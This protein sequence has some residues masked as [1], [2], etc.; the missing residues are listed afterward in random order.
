M[1][2]I[3]FFSLLWLSMLVF[4][5]SSAKKVDV[6]IDES[7]YPGFTKTSSGLY[8]KD[9]KEGTG[10]YLIRGKKVKLH[11][12]GKLEN[13]KIFDSSVDRN[14]PL[15]FV[16]GDLNFIKGFNE[17]LTT[18]RVGGKKILVIHPDIGYGAKDKEKIPPYSILI[19]EIE[20][21]SQE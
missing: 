16:Y 9:I 10:D 8:F 7:K 12:H 11:Y 21:L 13:G 19:F 4:G 18:I 15:E 20:V 5:C 3:C 14:Q 2:Y 1:K 6:V 17:A